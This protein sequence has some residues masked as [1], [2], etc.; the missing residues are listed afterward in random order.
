MGILLPCMFEK[1][2]VLYRWVSSFPVSLKMGILLPCIFEKWAVLYEWVS[3]FPV[4]L[5]MGILLPCMFEKNGQYFINGY[6]T[7][8]YV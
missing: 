1:W 6:L 3:S 2:A 7:S 4:C 8:L 5:K